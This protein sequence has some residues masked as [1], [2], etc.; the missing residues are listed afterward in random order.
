MNFDHESD[1]R[2]VVGM[3]G[4]G[5]TTLLLSIAEKSPHAWKFVFDPELEAARKLGWQAAST[6]E[7]LCRL[8]DNRRPVVF[9]PWDMF[10]DEAEQ[11]LEFFCRFVMVQ[12]RRKQGP[13]L[14]VIDELQESCSAHWAAMP[15][16]L[17]KICNTGRREEI[18]LL[19]GAQSLNDL[20]G[21]VRRQLREIYVFKQAGIDFAA[22]KALAKLNISAEQIQSL[23]M[24]KA[25]KRVG[26]IWKNCLTGESRL[27]QHKC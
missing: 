18:D 16:A 15:P 4:S 2:A 5:K 11:G 7:G 23:P 1:K 24:P 21:K 27:V 10:P 22:L 8:F 17:K 26:W 20:N 6:M 25:D 13:K 14:L 12:A 9:Y 3:T 19:L